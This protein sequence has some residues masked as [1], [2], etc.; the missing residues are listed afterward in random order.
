MKRATSKGS[1]CFRSHQENQAK[2]VPD[3]CTLLEILL[4][5]LSP[6]VNVNSSSK[7][8]IKDGAEIYNSGDG[9]C[10]RSVKRATSGKPVFLIAPGKPA[11]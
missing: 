6:N 10:G 8:G 7:N 5:L 3:V 2:Q 4:L 11:H 9:K 1:L